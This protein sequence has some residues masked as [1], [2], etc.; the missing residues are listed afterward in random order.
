M[1]LSR[2]ERNEGFEQNDEPTI[3][4]NEPDREQFQKGLNPAYARVVWYSDIE[5]TYH[6]CLNCPN[7]RTIRR[8]NIK[9]AIESEIRPMNRDRTRVTS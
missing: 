3:D 9:V 8:R 1:G 4:W 6:L 7:Y 2:F 5:D